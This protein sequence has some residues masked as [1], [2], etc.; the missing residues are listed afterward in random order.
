MTDK[1]DLEKNFAARQKKT[2]E[3]TTHEETEP[4]TKKG[5][6]MSGLMIA[7]IALVTASV[8]SLLTVVVYLAIVGG[9]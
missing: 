2:Q 7:A 9:L 5:K 6:K 8:A 4:V 3:P 1:E